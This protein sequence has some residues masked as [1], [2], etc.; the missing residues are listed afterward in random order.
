MSILKRNYGDSFFYSINHEIGLQEN[1][2]K[3]SNESILSDFFKEPVNKRSKINNKNRR[4]SQD[5]LNKS[6]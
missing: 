5:E 2:H 4:E 6:C 3:K 1:Q